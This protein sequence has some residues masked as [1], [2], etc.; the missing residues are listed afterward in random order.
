MN[1]HAEEINKSEKVRTAT[2][3]LRLTLHAKYKKVKLKYGYRKP[4]PK[5]DRSTT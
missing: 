1:T 4:I 3:I 5:S 2:K